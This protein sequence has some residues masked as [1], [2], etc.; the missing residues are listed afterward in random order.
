M[1][2]SLKGWDEQYAPDGLVIIGVHSPEFRHE[3]ELANVQRAVTELGIGYPVAQ[4]NDFKTW[5]LYGNRYWPTLY[6]IDRAG[7]IR[8]VH[9]GEGRYAETER[10]IRALLAEPAPPP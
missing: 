6:A 9:I 10:V 7:N 5:R 8:Y 4:D 3:H 1:I 2:P